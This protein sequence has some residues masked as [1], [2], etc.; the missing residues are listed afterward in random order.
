MRSEASAETAQMDDASN[1]G[2]VRP[3][4]LHRVSSCPVCY[5]RAGD[6]TLRCGHDLCVRCLRHW[7]HNC[8]MCR[9][10]DH[11]EFVDEEFVDSFD[12]HLN[13][14]RALPDDYDRRVGVFAHESGDGVTVMQL[15]KI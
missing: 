14:L 4:E 13:R 3:V 9:T 7:T 15:K 2:D 5:Q 1:P 11:L 10:E 12:E 8:P 6:V